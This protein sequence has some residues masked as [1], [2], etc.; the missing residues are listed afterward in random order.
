[1]QD[2]IFIIPE[3]WTSFNPE[4]VSLLSQPITIMDNWFQ[5]SNY[6]DSTAVMREAGLLQA[7]QYLI[8]AKVINGESIVARVGT[9]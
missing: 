3:G 9:D 1:M 5:T 4:Q 6:T 8:E 2:F 7:N